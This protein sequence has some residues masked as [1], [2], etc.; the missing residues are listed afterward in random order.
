[1]QSV[2]DAFEEVCKD[3]IAASPCYLVLYQSAP[4][5]GGPEEGGWWGIDTIVEAY[6]QYASKEL[7]EQD[8]IKI[9]ELAQKLTLESQKDYGEQCLRDMEWCDSRGLDADYLR[10]PDGP[11]SFFV[12]VE[13]GIPENHYGTRQYS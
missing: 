5:Y 8:L 13:D 1:M 7:A 4:Y 3:S 9:N 6:K 11:C 2:K 12:A 10:E